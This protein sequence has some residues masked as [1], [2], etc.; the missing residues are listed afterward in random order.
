MAC[1]TSRACVRAFRS[2]KAS[3]SFFK[4]ST[5]ANSSSTLR[6]CG[7]LGPGASG[8]GVGQVSKWSGGIGVVESN[9]S[10]SSTRNDADAFPMASR[11]AVRT[12]VGDTGAGRVG[13]TRNGLLS[14]AADR[15]PVWI[16]TLSSDR[17]G[18]PCSLLANREERISRA[19]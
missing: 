8:G 7:A 10:L 17:T 4:A 19:I 16:P 1:R 13:W 6:S 18:A 12:G 15:S 5:S 3:N 11:S 2:F 9:G 14:S